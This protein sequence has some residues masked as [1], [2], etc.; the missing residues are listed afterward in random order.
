MG[1]DRLSIV[2]PRP[3]LFV[4]SAF[5]LFLA[6]AV[7]NGATHGASPLTVLQA[8]DTSLTCEFVLRDLRETQGPSG[9]PVLTFVGAVAPP[10]AHTQGDEG[11]DLPRYVGIVGLPPDATPSVAV[12][13]E[14]VEHIPGTAFPG[15]AANVRTGALSGSEPLAL[16]EAMGYARER[17]LGRVVVRPVRWDGD[18]RL[19]VTRRLLFRVDFG[20]PQAAPALLG[21][22]LPVSQPFDDLFRDTVLNYEQARYWRSTRPTPAMAPASALAAAP[23]RLK[24]LVSQKGIYRVSPA[25]LRRLGV[26]PEEIDPTTFRLTYRGEEVAV[27]VIGG[28][29]GSFDGNDLL[30][31]YGEGITRDRFTATNAYML[32]WGGPEGLRPRVKD[33]TLVTPSNLAYRPIAFRGTDYF[34]KDR[35]H[36]SLPDVTGD[37]VDHYFWTGFTGG[38]RD[39]QRWQKT[40]VLPFPTEANNILDSAVLRVAFQGAPGDTE[41]GVG[42]RIHRMQTY[43]NNE[44]LNETIWQGQTGR[45]VE[46]A[47]PQAFVGKDTGLTF[48]CLDQNQTPDAPGYFDV[49]LDWIELDYW[50]DLRWAP[51]RR[52]VFISPTLYPAPRPGPVHY[53]VAGL[54]TDAVFVYQRTDTGLL[55]R[56][57]NPTVERDGAGYRATFEDVHAVPTPYCVV[58]QPDILAPD[59]IERAPFAGLQSPA[60]RADYLIITHPVFLDA[61]RQLADYRQSQGLD[62]KVVNVQDVYNEFNHGVFSP[63]AIQALLRFAFQVWEK[64]P[65]YVLLVGDGHYDYKGGET[66]AYLEAGQVVDLSPIFVPTI[67]GW[68]MPFGETAIDQRFVTVHGEDTIPDMFIGRIPAQQANELRTIIEKIIAYETRREVGSWQARIVHASDDDMTNPGDRIFQDSRERLIQQFIPPAYE[69]LRIYLKTEPSAD[70]ARGKIIRAIRE[71]ALLLEYSGHGGRWTWADEGMFR[72]S[73]IA[74]LQNGRRQPIVIATTCE[75]NFFDKPER[76]GDRAMGEEFL[77]GAERGAIATIGATR[78]TFALCN[79]DFDNVLFPELLSSRSLAAG[80]MLTQAKIRLIA[81]GLPIYCATSVEQYCLFGDPALRIARPRFRT[82][83]DGALGLDALSVNARQRVR[84]RGGALYD[85]RPESPALARNF[86]GNATVTLVPPNNLD[87][88][89]ANDVSLVQRTIPVVGGEFGDVELLLPAG[90]VPGE[91]VVRFYA[92]SATGTAIGGVRFSVGESRIIRLTH[93][94]TAAGLTVTADLANADGPNGVRAVEL[95]WWNSADFRQHMIPMNSVAPLRYV[96]GERIPLPGPGKRIHYHLFVSDVT[97]RTVESDTIFVQMPLGPDLAIA[98]LGR[99]GFPEIQYGF[100]RALGKWVFR[101]LLSNRGDERPRAPVEVVIALGNPDANGDGTLDG[102]ANILARGALSPEAWRASTDPRD[103]ERADIVLAL[104]EPLLSGVHD[105][106]IWIDPET[107]GDPHDDG[108]L[109][110]VLEP[111]ELNNRQRKPFEVSDFVVGTADVRAFSQDRTL[112]VNVPARSVEPTSLSISVAPPP[113][114]ARLSAPD[115]PFVAGPLPR[116]TNRGE[117]AFELRL[118]SGATRFAPP[119]TVEISLDYEAMRERLMRE[120]GQPVDPIARLPSHDR[121]LAEAL[122]HALERTA[123]YRWAEQH[124][125]WRV[126]ESA[127]LRDA[128]GAL[129]TSLHVTPA[130]ANPARARKLQIREIRV[131]PTTTP[132][133]QWM[134]VFINSREY[135]ILL[136]P[137]GAG[138]YQK[139]RV[140]GVL[141][142]PYADATVSLRRLVV[143]NSN[144]SDPGSTL[145]IPPEYGD[146]LLFDTIA[147]DEGGITVSNIRDANFGDGAV[148]VQLRDDLTGDPPIGDWLVLMR[149]DRQFELRD[150][151]GDVATFGRGIP[152]DNGEVGQQLRLPSLGLDILV[153]QGTQS[154]RFGDAFRFRV[155]RVVAMSART[156]AAGV[157]SL[158]E[159]RDGRSPSVQVWVN[160]QTPKSGSVIPPR[161]TVTL[162]LADRNGIDPDSFRL[163][164]EKVGQADPQPVP[165]DKYALNPVPIDQVSVRYRPILFIGTY[166]FRVRVRDMAGVSVGSAA[167]PFMDFVF[168]VDTDPDLESPTFS[169]ATELG[170]VRDGDVLGASPRRFVLDVRDSHAVNVGSVRIA[171]S[172]SG[173]APAPVEEGDV[174]VDFD[175]RVPTAARF[176]WQAD[177]ANGAYELYARGEDTSTNV[178]FVGP[179][180]TTPLRFV[181]DEP[182]R[183][184]GPVLPAPNPMRRDTVFAYHLSQPADRVTVRI[185]TSAGRLVRVLEGGSASRGYNETYWDGRDD[186]GT[187]TSNGA[188]LFKIRVESK[189]GREERV[190]KL[191]VLR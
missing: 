18:G 71:G 110:K 33:G 14:E 142:E 30:L 121:Q 7:S 82:G 139:L 170:P 140:R 174:T 101:A 38:L 28:D 171:L 166:V 45:V 176:S 106:A 118:Q 178:G 177:L 44:F 96:N 74:G 156:D 137:Q 175:R 43:V 179:D 112:H 99:T 95:L 77:L 92:E 168:A 136:K 42:L 56:I 124:N 66:A 72:G 29:D 46:V 65:T 80:A 1:V 61:V 55:A 57:K 169:V 159:D 16:A 59:A 115:S 40:L 20:R 126:L 9:V 188:Y 133:A 25:D 79:V 167:E 26:S 41:G 116:L 146:V 76:A 184:L 157:F 31:F 100:D 53:S 154:Y 3:R 104:D 132:P 47:F 22:P 119:A 27:D 138:A 161:P 2:R 52:G 111:D 108:M 189:F 6:A 91:A 180:E 23:F 85:T 54:P 155:S 35:I 11:A 102:N 17:Y 173:E 123:V 68:S 64:P 182:V 134:L 153:L 143:T 75:M 21:R 148:K 34:E 15:V 187:Q 24:L 50:Q 32:S 165:P 78:L 83:T 135:E 125:A 51:G 94:I 86:D 164:V 131:D 186:E 129:Q 162:L 152:V 19:R 87:T 107:E 48:R 122:D 158:L 89:I 172:R 10:H 8:G 5:F 128:A 130:L 190:G 149:D 120:L 150:A 60:N 73:D 67:H 90:A 13:H 191:A 39:V 144:P 105:I 88:D 63:F 69:V 147:T 183:L 185:Y 117:A 37:R 4:S 181:V 12:L 58:A 84:V 62:V 114:S 113:N 49:Y 141:D 70:T 160:D 127:P 163:E 98:E 151:K 97:G 103:F 145:P 109:G 36:D 81:T 93:Q